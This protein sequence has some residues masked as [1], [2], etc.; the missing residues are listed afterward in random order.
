MRPPSVNELTTIIFNM[1]FTH[2]GSEASI[3]QILTFAVNSFENNNR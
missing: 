2:F 3:K 1:E